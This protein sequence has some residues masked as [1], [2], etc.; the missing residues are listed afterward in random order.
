ML[1][2]GRLHER[3]GAPPCSATNWPPAGCSISFWIR[4][5]PPARARRLPIRSP[6][7][8][9][10]RRP[11]QG[12]PL[13][14]QEVR[15]QK[16]RH[17]FV[18]GLLLTP[19]GLRIPYR[20]F[21]YTQDL[22]QRA[23][24]TAPRPSGGRPDREL[25]PPATAA[26]SSWATP[27]TRPTRR[28]GLRP[29]AG[30]GSS[31]ATPNACWPVKSH[32]PSYVHCFSRVRRNGSPRSRSTPTPTRTP[33]KGAGRRRPGIEPTRSHILGVAAASSRSTPSGEVQVFVSTTKKPEWGQPLQ[34][35][36]ILLS[37]D[38]G[39]TAREAVLRYTMR[40]QIELFF[41]ECK[42]ILGM[43][44]YRFPEFV[45]VERWM[46]LVWRCTCIWNGTGGG[47][48]EDPGLTEEER[49]W[50]KSQRTAGLCSRRALGPGGRRSYD[51]W[52]KRGL[53]T[54]G[55]CKRLRR[56][57]A[58]RLATRPP[59][60]PPGGLT[61][62]FGDRAGARRRQP[63]VAAGETV[64]LI[65]PSGGGKSTLL[66]CLNGLNIL[67]RRRDPRRAAHVLTAAIGGR[68]DAR[69]CSSCAGCS[70]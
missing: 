17:A 59:G 66:R 46:D 9:A 64:A 10:R 63:A 20:R 25:E 52:G 41:K 26:W 62:R 8:T 27:P 28:T 30:P 45:R 18:C 24:P 35:P 14:H 69:P 47:G 4:P 5:L 70:A 51:G 39:L 49:E 65:G 11:R 29:G 55:G 32:V 56:L 53:A 7:A 68:D 43:V 50:W 31:P 3:P 23:H 67:R 44:Q 57:S 42:S 12:P 36:K 38:L 15:L 61:K 33:P 2:P 6:P 13:Q 16:R 22:R 60:E 58:R 1:G 37:N 34:E 54:P 21:Y 48:W 19:S 40:W